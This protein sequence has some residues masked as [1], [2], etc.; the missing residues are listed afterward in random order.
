[1][2]EGSGMQIRKVSYVRTHQLQAMRRATSGFGTSQLA[3]APASWCLRSAP[4]V[5]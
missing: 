1:M 2:Q 4:P 3:R 5:R